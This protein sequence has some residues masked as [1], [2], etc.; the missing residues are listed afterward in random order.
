M[1]LP[2]P[3]TRPDPAAA[4]VCGAVTAYAAHCGPLLG[5][6]RLAETPEE[7]MRS[8]YT[9]YA[10]GETD[11]VWRTWHPRTRP[12]QVTHDPATAWVGLEV[13]DATDDVVEFV[14]HW[15]SGREQGRLHEVSVFERRAAR[16]FYVGP[17]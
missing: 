17:R 1:A 13:L 15:R 5:A 11:H 10:V 4:C 2:D 16:W 8:R 9:A 14:A 12:A 6:E 7:L 3:T